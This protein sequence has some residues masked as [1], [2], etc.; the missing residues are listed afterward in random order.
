MAGSRLADEA[1]R[2]A[3]DAYPRVLALRAVY[4]DIDSFQH[5]NNVAI[6]RFFEEGRAVINMEAFGED[7]VVRPSSGEQLLFASVS[8]EYL[9]QGN[10]PGELLVGTAVSRIG[11]SSF[12]HS[13]ALFQH[14]RPIALCDAVTV[15]A[16]DGKSRPLPPS[17]RE[18]LEAL[19]PRHTEERP[20]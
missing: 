2:L 15:Y 9:A 8:V 7:A 17:A 10:Y 12:V 18:R 6:S 3:A 5:L 1:W 11:G 13:A 20:V 19:R 14:G 16:V 4:G